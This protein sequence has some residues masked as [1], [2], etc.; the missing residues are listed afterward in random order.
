[1][2]LQIT[3]GRSLTVTLKDT[4]KFVI[5]L[6][7]VWKKHPYHQDYLG[8]YTIDSH[9]LSPRVHGLLG[10]FYHGVQFEVSNLHP[11]EDPEKPDATMDVKG[12]KLTVT[13][14]WQRDFRRD[15]KNG[16]K[17]PCWFV[18]SNGTGLIDGSHGDY[19]VSNLF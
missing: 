17:V 16:E 15:V 5:I 6:H 14:G 19:V 13:R 8:F 3:K 11:G 2:D 1:M 9:L 18:H 12:H 7:K 4:V 10:Q